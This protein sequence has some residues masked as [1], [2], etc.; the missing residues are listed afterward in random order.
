MGVDLFMGL[1]YKEKIHLYGSCSALNNV[2]ST[3]GFINM[4]ICSS[5]YVRKD[6]CSFVE[7]KISIIEKYLH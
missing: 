7:V 6:H 4:V 3:N 5:H 1:V 2:C